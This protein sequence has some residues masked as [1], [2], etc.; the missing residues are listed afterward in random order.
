MTFI[1]SFCE[2]SVDQVITPRALK[3]IVKSYHGDQAAEGDE[4]VRPYGI[5]TWPLV[6]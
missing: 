1:M 4:N 5:T 2:V 3:S 6:V